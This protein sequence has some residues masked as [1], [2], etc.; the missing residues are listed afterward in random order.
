MYFFTAFNATFS[1]CCN[2]LQL[3]LFFA[4]S[5]TIHISKLL[6]YQTDYKSD[7]FSF[8]VRYR[9]NYMQNNAFPIHS[10]FFPLYYLNSSAFMLYENCKKKSTHNCKLCS[11]NLLLCCVALV[12]F[13]KETLKSF[14]Q[15]TVLTFNFKLVTRPT[16]LQRC[17]KT[18]PCKN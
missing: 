13:S 11:A 10:Y 3:W 15:A 12:N 17:F 18:F 6:F 5:P 1:I 7:N 8:T 9:K 14:Y 16:E 2:F 4:P